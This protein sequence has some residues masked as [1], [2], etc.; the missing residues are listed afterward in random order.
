MESLKKWFRA[1]FIALPK[2]LFLSVKMYA[3]PFPWSILWWMALLTPPWNIFWWIVGFGVYKLMGGKN[4]H[5]G[6]S[7]QILIFAPALV[8]MS[9]VAL[10]IVGIEEI[11][12]KTKK[13]LH[14]RAAYWISKELGKKGIQV[15]KAIAPYGGCVVEAEI[16]GHAQI[17]SYQ[18]VY[19][20]A[21]RKFSRLSLK[22]IC[23]RAKPLEHLN[24]AW[25]EAEG[26]EEYAAE[27]WSAPCVKC[28]EKKSLGVQWGNRESHEKLWWSDSVNL[29]SFEDGAE[30]EIAGNICRKCFRKIPFVSASYGGTKVSRI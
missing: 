14:L 27:D 29:F 25:A 19:A 30:E 17:S 5:S 24:Q 18:E 4:D 11:R 10:S 6:D 12:Y 20:R 16:A 2:V 8:P 9:L 1:W 15:Y 7:V 13:K 23:S 26:L 22:E 28:G 3:P 21:V